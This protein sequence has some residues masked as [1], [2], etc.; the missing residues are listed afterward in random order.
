MG[1]PALVAPEAVFVIVVAS[2][3]LFAMGF[4]FQR[5]QPWKKTCIPDLCWMTGPTGLSHLFRVDR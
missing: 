5:C 3:I 1:G 2:Q 4:H